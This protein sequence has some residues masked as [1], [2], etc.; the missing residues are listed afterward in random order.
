MRSTN[1]NNCSGPKEQLIPTISAS[2]ASIKIAAA[3][4]GVPVMVRPSSLKEN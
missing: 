3:S 4:G 1:G 2:I